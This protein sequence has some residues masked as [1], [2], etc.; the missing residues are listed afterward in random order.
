MCV[1]FRVKKKCLISILRKAVIEFRIRTECFNLETR[2]LLFC[3]FIDFFNFVIFYARTQSFAH[4]DSIY[5]NKQHHHHQKNHQKNTTKM[6]IDFIKW[7]NKFIYWIPKRK[8]WNKTNHHQQHN[9]THTGDAVNR[10]LQCQHEGGTCEFFLTCWM[11]NGLLQGTC[12]G[13]LRGCCHRIAKSANS[14]ANDI[15]DLTDLPSK[16]YGPITNDPSECDS[17]SYQTKTL[18]FR[19]AF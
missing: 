16:E 10:E 2:C 1:S 7:N 9:K 6:I 5:N 3:W 8:Q 19:M 18:S 14:G 13:V 11:T 15:V 4:N 17:F 12:G